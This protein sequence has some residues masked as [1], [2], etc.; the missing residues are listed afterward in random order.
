MWHPMTSP[1]ETR[2]WRDIYRNRIDVEKALKQETEEAM[3]NAE[4]AV[5]AS[6]EQMLAHQAIRVLL[7]RYQ[8]GDDWRDVAD[9]WTVAFD[10]LKRTQ[11]A[12]DA[13]GAGDFALS[14]RGITPMFQAVWM[15]SFGIA[16]GRTP[17]EIEQLLNTVGPP[18]VCGLWERLVVLVRNGSPDAGLPKARFKSP[19]QALV[20]VIDAPVQT[21]TKK[22]RGYL[23]KWYASLKNTGWHETHRRPDGWEFTGARQMYEQDMW[24]HGY[25]GYW[26]FE[27]ALVTILLKLDDAS[28]RDHENFPRDLL[29]QYRTTQQN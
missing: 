11:A 14:L 18:N 26:S 12:F 8:R 6:L 10:G 3:Q 13:T 9:A 27:S 22:L 17:S 29:D 21:R 28:Y 23:D 20:D 16:L 1:R 19:F 15:L 2:F 5:K 25:F 7:Y 4:P 24:D